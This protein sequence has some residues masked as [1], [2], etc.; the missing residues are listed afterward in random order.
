MTSERS[1]APLSALYL[2]AGGRSGPA[3]AKRAWR[4]G[5][6]WVPELLVA[7]CAAVPAGGVAGQAPDSIRADS[8]AADTLGAPGAEA[9][10][11]AADPAEALGPLVD[12]LGIGSPATE[13]EGEPGPAP[14]PVQ[15]APPG[16]VRLGLRTVPLPFPIEFPPAPGT[17][18][19]WPG[20]PPG[21]GSLSE[22]LQP[23]LADYVL[24]RP[25]S[26][27]LE[28]DTVEFL[29]PLPL[30]EI[31]EETEAT[32]GGFQDLFEEYTDLT[33][34]LRG[35]AEMGGDWTSFRPCDTGI[36]FTC[37]APIIPRLTPELQFGLQVG[38]TVSDRVHVNVDYDQTR[39][40]SAANN[41]N[42]YYQGLEDEIL[43]RVEVGD[44]SYQLP[45][46]SR[47][48]TEGIP[49][50]NFG[51]QTTGQ[52]G[53][54]D[55]Q[56][57][58][59][60]QKGD[61]SSSEFRLSGAGGQ[62]AFVQEDTLTLD[63][64]DYVSGQYF[65][66][67]D[68]AE[69]AGYPH[70]DILALDPASAPMDLVPGLEQVQV[71][72]FENDPITAQQVQGY[73]QAD[74][75][76]GT[77]EGDTLRESGWFRYLQPDVDYFVHPSGLWMAL[78]SPLRRDEMLAVTYIAQAGDTIG[79]YN[80]ERLYNE[81][82]RPTLRLLKASGPNHQPEA[83][84][85]ATEMHQIY[86]VSGSNDVEVNSVHLTVSL[87]E[88]GAGQTF[89]RGTTGADI[90]FLRLFGL[91]EEAPQDQ[92]DRATVYKPAED[93]FQDQPPV[94]GTFIV[95]KTL[96]PFLTPPPVP[97]LGLS[98][99]D[100][101]L[102][103][104]EDANRIIYQSPDPVERQA[105]G[106]FRLT[107]PHRVRSEGVV[108]TFNLGALGIRDASEKIFL[109]ERLLEARV[110][111]I[112]DYDVGQVT[113][114]DAQNL[115][116]V[117]PDADIRATWEQKTVFQIAPTSVFGFN[118]A[119]DVGA[120]GSLNF[121][122]LFQN[123]K[124]LVRRPQLGV[125][126]KAV[127]LG[128]VN[129]QFEIGAS[130]LDR[131]LDKIPGLYYSGTSAIRMNG[132]LAASL[133]NPNTQGDVYIDDFDG[134]PNLPLSPLSTA[135][136][137][138]S[139]P[140]RRDGAGGVLPPALDASDNTTLA[141]Q[142]A[143]VQGDG[144]V[145]EGLFPQD[146]DQQI[147]VAGTAVRDPVMLATFGA[148]QTFTRDRWTGITTVLSTTGL[149][150]TKTEFLEFYASIAKQDSLVMIIDIGRV[151]EDAFFVD[152]AGATAGVKEN[153][154]TW[155]LDLL[156]EEA[157]L[158]LGEVWSDEAD[159]RG[160]WGEACLASAGTIYTVGSPQANCTRGNGRVDTEDLDG[161]GNL[162]RSERYYRYVV[163]FD[164][165]SPFLARDKSE[166]G[167][168]FEFYKIALRGED[169][170]N[171]DG[172][173][174]EA[175]WRAVKHLRITFVGNA[176]NAALLARMKL[177][178]SRWVKRAQTGI[179]RGL[180]GDTLGMGGRL[181]V[182]PVSALTVSG[183]YSSPPGVLEELDNP[184]A[185][186]GGTSIE[187]NEQSLGLDYEDISP[188][189][190]V[191]V[192]NRFPQRPRNFL[193]YRE[194]RIWSVAREGD[195][196]TEE[197]VYFFVKV[198]NDADNYY[199]Y[200]TRLEPAA[201]GGAV[202]PNDWLPENVIDF[203]VWFDLRRDAE[204]DL[205]V[206]PPATGDPPRTLWSAD[207]TY[208]VV[209]QDRGRAP[210]LYAV[211]EMSLGVMNESNQPIDG[212]LW[213]N[214]FRLSRAV[215]DA[216]VAGYM[217]L[218][219]RAADV[220]SARVS[221][222]DQGPFFRQLKDDPTYRSD[223]SL[224]ITSTLQA[225]RFAPAPWGLEIPLTVTHTSTGVDP[226]FLPQS[227]IQAGEIPNLRETG[228]S[229][230]RVQASFRK[231]TPTASTLGSILLDGLDARIGYSK[232][233]TS[234]VTFKSESSG[235]DGSLG[236]GRVLD[237]KTFD[238]IPSFI[239]PVI[240]FLFPQRLEEQIIGSRLRWTPERFTLRATYNQQDNQNF[241]Y[242]QILELPRDSIV[243]PT[244]S[245][246]EGLETTA[247]MS[248]RPF[249]SLTASV[250]VSTSRGLLPP[251]DAT[252]DTTS[253][254]LIEEERQSFLGMDVG[255]LVNQTVRTQLGF[256]PAVTDWLRLDLGMNATYRT[257]RNPSFVQ[258]T[259][260]GEEPPPDDS[261]AV[262]A[263]T[264][265]ELSRNAATIRDRRAGF[266]LDPRVLAFGS[267]GDAPQ[268]GEST[269]KTAGRAA[270]AALQP[271]RFTWLGG[272]SSRFNRQVVD[273][274]LGYR[275]GFGSFD[276]FRTVDGQTASF[277]T[278]RSS[279]TTG[280]GIQF[281]L[282][283]SVDVEYTNSRVNTVD[284]RVGRVN[285]ER[286]WP[287]VQAG[288][289]NLLL[290]GAVGRVLERFTLASGY[291]LTTRESEVTGTAQQTRTQ[292]DRRIPLTLSLRWAGN[293]STAYS[294]SFTSGEGVDPAGDTERDRQSHSVSVSSSF[295]P[296]GNFGDRLD[297]PIQLIARFQYSSQFDCRVT[298][299]Q[300]P[301]T[302]FVDQI[303]RTLNVSMDS[304]I[305][306]FEMG[307]N[308]TFTDRQSFIGTRGGSSQVQFGIWG[309]FNL[310]AGLV[311]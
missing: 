205:I 176:S 131:F 201:N 261:T 278:E 258:Q 58:W 38:G 139:V 287:D 121:L 86:R 128:G 182:G 294:G 151:D 95:F 188:G 126:S 91:D 211:R 104:G 170:T 136:K 200:R 165:T 115:F 179:V 229:R 125:E 301:C 275:L 160:N 41:I 142:H 203:D 300:S 127:A 296:P 8:L 87:G 250:G 31:E 284:T 48:L 197:P 159:R 68:P 253:Q 191:E 120:F 62:Q 265:S 14:S 96:E 280:S 202:Q 80:P 276:S 88:L 259:V 236:Y 28:A 5:S 39:E 246:R 166:T 72:R 234:N 226:F 154:Q 204:A 150:L 169:G 291:Q 180:G 254:R 6:Q 218:D 310:Q 269:M 84:T 64:A 60:Q 77:E 288:F 69:I 114:L 290:P 196:G 177:V 195:W 85:W 230:T 240:R 212:E 217:D 244:Q 309:Q 70:L 122:G 100:T 36:Q 302:P 47:F 141:W 4:R 2:P 257:D 23:G 190:R 213:I 216:G 24:T 137:L 30:S 21:V 89:K 44:V 299:A 19:L 247:E 67:F 132:E 148:N 171:V 10:T 109:G 248:L 156:D 303:N 215:R 54:V 209:L 140:K 279:I 304:A 143:W 43:Q 51:F 282:S 298:A 108:S 173:F 97:S 92:L 158:Q 227:D 255:W 16:T 63:D 26:A 167:T 107:I 184:T 242:E 193:T 185:A 228:S 129:G 99:E 155:G 37:N 271:I 103:L 286:T 220:L 263:D 55:F 311:P 56:A 281:P 270:L 268:A 49:A 50:G 124:A 76:A 307:L 157:Q 175:D 78:R 181:E 183:A 32:G 162:D 289:A 245:P 119:T 138:A 1:G 210:N 9:D 7:L 65:F 198:G 239:E 11:L 273:P 117:A 79:D 266:N 168:D 232:A 186:I 264:L 82:T 219:L 149:D 174:T 163:T 83:P 252:P 42:V 112:I 222:S 189:D 308:L 241:R 208:A 187:F 145:F 73:I 12:S 153:G 33:M 13:L 214:E 75:V 130:W 18:S 260:V 206:N 22:R 295:T 116:A 106:L 231:R 199:L 98:A 134:N 3:R 20:G 17:G 237:S 53:P 118:A 178:G 152:S 249:E 15:E 105:G 93:S 221:Y 113:L 34:R 110:D 144:R 233:S 293:V 59:A 267:F 207:S 35:R 133:P 71:Y 61:L 46:N 223:R 29:P 172:L 45:P 90:T 274:D 164:G 251:E 111:Y 102:I 161:N 25:V 283:F 277:A 224:N 192:F 225:G 297:R 52:L 81:G 305:Q 57:V 135:W 123:E 40:F 285:R 235:L 94:S 101:K 243:A 194:A 292:E 146:I 147:N 262:P 74:A 306:Q 256:R 66:F 27:T 272:T 238:Y